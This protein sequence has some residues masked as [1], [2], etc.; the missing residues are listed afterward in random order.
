MLEFKKEKNWIMSWVFL[1]ELTDSIYLAESGESVSDLKDGSKQL[2]IVKSM[3]IVEQSFFP[4][5]TKD[6]FVKLLS[7][8]MSKPLN[9]D[10]LNQKSISYF[11]DSHAKILALQE[12][13]K[14]WKESEADCFSRSFAWPKKSSP[15]SYSLKMCQQLQQE[16][17]LELL[18]KL[19]KWGMIV[20][21]VLYPLHPLEHITKERDGSYWLTPTTMDTLPIRKDNALENALYRGKE[22][23]YKRKVSGRL[24]E[25]VSYPQ[26]W[27]TPIASVRGARKNQNGH[28]YTLQDAVGSGKLNPEWIE[29]L[30]GYNLG[31]TEL[32][33]WVIPWFRARSKKRSKYY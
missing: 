22:R 20:D 4:E 32:E 27:P 23:K 12:L 13:K 29:W 31:W 25:Q 19:P 16:A 26:M 14:A 2:P 3:C 24:N 10:Q 28:H 15:L 21:G 33:L 17:D 1:A 18:E 7:G 5:C 9:Q 11:L 8:T 30:M 6:L